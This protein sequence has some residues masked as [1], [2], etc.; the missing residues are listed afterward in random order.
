M[1][2]S[3]ATTELSRRL[4]FP[5]SNLF[6]HA[7]GWLDVAGRSTA[8]EEYSIK[9]LPVVWKEAAVVPIYKKLNGAVMTNYRFISV[10]YIVSKCF[11]VSLLF[12]ISSSF[13][14][15]LNC[16]QLSM[17]LLNLNRQ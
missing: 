3:Q 9:C 14:L 4:N 6:S 1:L 11:K 8:S 13:L 17:D 7:L 10:L 16:T 2:L 15:N 12:M 5:H